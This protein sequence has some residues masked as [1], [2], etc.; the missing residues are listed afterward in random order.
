[1][2]VLTGLGVYI[3]IPVVHLVRLL[4]PFHR[5]TNEWSK[6][7]PLWDEWKKEQNRRRLNLSLKIILKK[8]LK[9]SLTSESSAEHLMQQ[10]HNIVSIKFELQAFDTYD[11][12]TKKLFYSK[13]WNL[14]FNVSSPEIWRVQPLNLSRELFQF[15][16]YNVNNQQNIFIDSKL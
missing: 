6:L 9:L 16:C 8:N 1:M 14:S 4:V 11:A 13:Q 7:R 5:K 10:S 3:S 15:S 12:P 2:F